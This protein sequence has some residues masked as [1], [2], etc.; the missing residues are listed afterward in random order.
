VTLESQRAALLCVLE[1][2]AAG[3]FT[4]EWLRRRYAGKGL[5]RFFAERPNA[6]CITPPAGAGGA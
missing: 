5:E 2:R 3:L 1:G 6:F 4:T